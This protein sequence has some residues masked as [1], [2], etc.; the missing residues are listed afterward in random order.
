MI[1]GRT[2]RRLVALAAALAF[3]AAQSAAAAY[4]C[5]GPAVAATVAAQAESPCPEHF[6]A[7]KGDTDESPN[8]CEV[9][10]QDASVAPLGVPACAP[11]P[12]PVLAIPTIAAPSE[13]RSAP[14]PEAKGAPPPIRS[15]YCRLQ[16]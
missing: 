3:V 10:C 16:L 8:L 1:A 15:L 9:H 6:A 2:L 13:G 7:S 14:A 11:P 5:A 12:D 4:A